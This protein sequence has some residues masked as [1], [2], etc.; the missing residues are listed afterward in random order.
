MISVLSV[1]IGSVLGTATTLLAGYRWGYRGLWGAVA[2][3]CGVWVL[4]QICCSR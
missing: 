2:A 1:V 3:W 4:F